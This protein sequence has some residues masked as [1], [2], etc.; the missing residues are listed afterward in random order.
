MSLGRLSF[1]FHNVLTQWMWSPFTIGMAALLVGLGYW[2]LRADWLL[3]ARGRRWPGGRTAFFLGGLFAVELAIGSPV[4]S[5]T[6]YYF[7]AHIVQHLLLMA[8]APALLA[9]GAPSTLLLQTVSRKNKSRWLKVLNS[10]PFAVLTHP[11]SVWILY[12]GFM[13]AFF[14]TPLIN[15]AM[16]H[17]PLMDVLNLVFLL[18]GCLYW[19]PM[20]G[21]DP[22]VRWKIGYGANLANMLLGGAVET[23]LGVV[24]LMQHNPIGSMY[25]LAS[26]H[27]GGGL[28]W[29][30]TELVT[31]GGCIPIVL[32]WMR[33]DQR[34]AARADRLA[35]A[36]AVADA[37]AEVG[38]NGAR[39]GVGEARP[40]A[41]PAF[42]VAGADAAMTTWESAWLARTG[43]VPSTR[44]QRVP[45]A[46]DTEP[47]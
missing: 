23:F 14:L 39:A 36:R 24:I 27:A 41:G 35:D 44:A 7:E 25:T 43:S 17:M 46:L 29:V 9:L 20:V 12:F 21:K 40:A 1:S 42:Q 31:V 32:A 18:G 22:V 47:R 15:T 10:G 33:S 2:Y 3:A 38:S 37:R 13:F 30:S 16:L 8:A 6:N 45:P 4:A 34:A 26:T 5:F 11:L 19:W 28:L